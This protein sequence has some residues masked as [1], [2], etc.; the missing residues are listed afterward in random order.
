MLEHAKLSP[1]LL[2]EWLS[3]KDRALMMAGMASKTQS[4]EAVARLILLA[5]HER[6]RDQRNTH[7]DQAMFILDRAG[8]D[9]ERAFTG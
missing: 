3:A 7:L 6:C 2:P 5:Q 4:L 8:V 9:V 1:A